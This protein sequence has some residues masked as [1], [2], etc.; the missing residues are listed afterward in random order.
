MGN[1]T[2]MS[3]KDNHPKAEND[4]SAG[5]LRRSLDLAEAERTTWLAFRVR[6]HAFRKTK[7]LTAEII[8]IEALG[9]W[10]RAFHRVE[11]NEVA[12]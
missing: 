2:D 1:V 5:H 9:A 8:M 7:T 10:E 11:H 12:A 4:N 6:R 3:G